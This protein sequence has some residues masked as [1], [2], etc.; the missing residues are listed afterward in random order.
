MVRIEVGF[1]PSIFERSSVA[2]MKEEI[3]NRLHGLD[4]GRF[5]IILKKP[6]GREIALQFLGDPVSVE[7]AR[8]VLGIY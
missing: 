4:L 7:K 3:Q 8:R 6:L 5:K 1:T 2:Q